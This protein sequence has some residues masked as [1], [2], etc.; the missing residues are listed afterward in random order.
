MNR[1]SSHQDGFT[2]VE[3][4]VVVVIVAI[5]AAIAIPSYQQYVR[6]VQATQAQNQLQQIAM[7]LERHKS[8]NFNYQGFVMPTGMAILPKGATG[9]A[10]KYNFTIVSG[11]GGQSWVVTAESKDSRN[12]SF[13]MS[14][15]GLRCKNK[16]WT[17]INTTTITCGAGHE[18]W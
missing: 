2:L 4:I 15:R 1:Y 5:F 13:L 9:A 6:R 11:A 14:S 3:V 10:V 8:R 16:T 18:E 7:A 12:F 17:N